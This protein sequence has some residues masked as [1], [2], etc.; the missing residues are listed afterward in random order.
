MATDPAT[1]FIR[2]RLPKDFQ[3]PENICLDNDKTNER[4]L[5]KTEVIP[6]PEC[7][8]LKKVVLLISRYPLASTKKW[9]VANEK[10]VYN[11]NFYCTNTN[12][13]ICL[14]EKL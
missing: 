2:I 8:A 11:W 1:F 14:P 7:K 4:L 5:T 10:D 12:R 9:I 13:K 3:L 6:V